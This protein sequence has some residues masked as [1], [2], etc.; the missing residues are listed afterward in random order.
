MPNR[1]VRRSASLLLTLLVVGVVGLSAPSSARALALEQ[2]GSFDRPTFVTSD[3]N[4]PDRLFVVEQAGRIQLVQENGTSTFLDLSPLVH[5]LNPFGDYGMFS[6]AFSPHYARDHLFYV[7][8]SGVDD[9]ATAGDESGDLHVDEFQAS[10]DTADPTSRRQ[11]LT[12]GLSPY[13]F[14][15]GGQLRFGPD[16]YLYISTGDGGTPG[17][18]DGNS[19]NLASLLGKILRIDP[20][21]SA[22]GEYTVPRD[23]P[24]TATAGCTDGCDEIW[25]YGLRNPWRFSFDRLTGDLAIGDVGD[26]NWEEVDFDTGRHPGKGDNF[27]WSCREAE[28][29]GPGY[30]VPV[31]TDR[32]G[33]FTEPVFEY[34]HESSGACAITGGYVVR[35]RSLG[36]LYGRYLYADFCTGELRSVKLGV[37]TGSADRSEGAFVPRPTSFGEGSD[38]RIYAA[39]FNGPVYQLTGPAK[40]ATTGCPHQAAP[41]PRLP[42]TLRLHAEKQG[43]SKQL[44][45]FATASAD[46]TLTVLGR[47]IE[48]TEG[49]LAANQRSEVTAVLKRTTRK[50]LREKLERKGEARIKIEVSVV[51]QADAV[52]RHNFEVALRAPWHRRRR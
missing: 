40:K 8:Y 4:D 1:Y 42:L 15:Y 26:W 35:D 49:K 32:L 23:N 39:T 30:T 47:G 44:R 11:V 36:D 19:Q 38:C 14:H 16:G 37:P 24:F 33:T 34:P 18:S 21:G 43:L 41:E 50:R 22:P 20:R 6:M 5:G 7:A 28:H 46:S 29:P 25:S 48:K 45:F 31:C 3:P 13:H 51:D 27:G 17:D 9:P 10:G 12:I 52:V 2:I